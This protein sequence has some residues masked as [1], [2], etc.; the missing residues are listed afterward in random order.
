[1]KKLLIG[2]LSF[3]LLTVSFVCV[4]F[5]KEVYVTSNTVSFSTTSMIVTFNTVVNKI[6]VINESSSDIVQV[7]FDGSRIGWNGAKTTYTMPDQWDFR[8]QPNS[9][10]SLD[11]STDKIGL[12]GRAVGSTG[13]GTIT[14]LA[15]S[16]RRVS[17][18]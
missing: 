9:S 16:D 8:L 12:K 1:M 18:D 15:T 14:Y 17:N 2:L 13:T 10:V 5:A 4:S 6:L 3:A 7:E 11:I